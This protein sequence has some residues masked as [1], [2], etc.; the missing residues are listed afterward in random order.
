[1][2]IQDLGLQERLLRTSDLSSEK[3]IDNCTSAE[4]PRHQQQ[5]ICNI[6]KLKNNSTADVQRITKNNYQARQNGKV[7]GRS[8]E[9]NQGQCMNYSV[10]KYDG[11]KFGYKHGPRNCPSF[12]KKCSICNQTNHFKIDVKKIKGKS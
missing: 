12:R 2:G 5:L 4:L 8:I 3:T 10:E 11:I 9:V 1:M 6:D 7:N